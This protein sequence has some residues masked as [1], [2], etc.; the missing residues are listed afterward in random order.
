MV[1][2]FI[3]VKTVLLLLVTLSNYIDLFLSQQ[4]SPW[5][6]R[7]GKLETDLSGSCPSSRA[8]LEI[9]LLVSPP[10]DYSFKR[11]IF[12]LETKKGVKW[13][14]KGAYMKTRDDSIVVELIKHGDKID[15]SNFRSYR[16]NIL[17]QLFQ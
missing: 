11:S 8:K 2:E 16:K 13:K 17:S 12:F 4:C 14:L 7:G 6:D 15:I 3:S 1:P 10:F 5:A 9:Y